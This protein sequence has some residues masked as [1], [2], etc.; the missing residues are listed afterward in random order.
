MFS[1]RADALLSSAER[2]DLISV[3]AGTPFA[4][5][6]VPD[7]GGIRKVRFAG[8]GRGKRGGFR[9]IYY[10]S[11]T[12]MPVLALLIYGK[13]EQVNPTA[14]QRR[15]MAAVVAGLNATIRQ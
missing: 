7:P 13:N 2:F 3:L 1:R 9:V 6:L 11:G 12:D 5:G 15:A 10:V 4:G 14:E 8:G